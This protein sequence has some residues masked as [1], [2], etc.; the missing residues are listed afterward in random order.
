MFVRLVFIF[1]LV[2][3]FCLRIDAQSSRDEGYNHLRQGDNA[4]AMGQ[5]DIA[6]VHYTNAIQFDVTWADPLM[7]R[8]N[9]LFRMG[10]VQEALLDYNKAMLINPYSEFIYDRRAKL[11]ILASDLSG[12]QKDLDSLRSIGKTNLAVREW[13][14]E[15][16]LLM[17]DYANAIL[18]LDTLQ[19]LGEKNNTLKIRRAMIYVEWGH[20]SDA[21]TI[22]DSISG[23]QSISALVNDLK[24]TIAA[25]RGDDQAALTYF[26]Q[27]I[28]FMP[29]FAVSYFNRGM[30]YLKMGK[31]ELAE[32]DFK[33]AFSLSLDKSIVALMLG[34]T[35]LELGQQNEALRKFDSAILE[36]D[37]TGYLYFYRAQS[38][39]M[40][41]DYGG[42]FTDVNRSISLEPEKASNYLL[43]G[44]IYLMFSDYREA[45]D[46]FSTAISL[47]PQYSEAYHNRGLAFIMDGRPQLGCSDLYRALNLGYA[48][49]EEMIKAFCQYR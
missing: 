21:N 41:G 38:K 33:N 12:A 39:K 45:I 14:S 13:L 29:G 5:W 40:L 3:S 19:M 8:A 36:N 24:G 25:K 6:I 28:R 46:D 22:M 15:D 1:L 30:V 23:D 31:H 44:N 18:E 27:A 32:S 47:F 2:T 17:K 35:N 34:I 48:F 16:F 11:K 43:R 37:T 49:S 20:F 9:L 42:A 4:L 10:R 26:S 7:K